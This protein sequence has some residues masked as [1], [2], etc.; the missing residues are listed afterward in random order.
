[1]R[2]RGVPGRVAKAEL[3][4]EDETLIYSFDTKV[5]GKDGVT[6]VHVDAKTGAV[7]KVEGES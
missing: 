4:K 1:M 5:V 6:E 3:E 7:L 2:P